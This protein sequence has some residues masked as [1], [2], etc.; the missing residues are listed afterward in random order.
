MVIVRIRVHRRAAMVGCVTW[1]ANAAVWGSGVLSMFLLWDSTCAAGPKP[2]CDIAGQC[3][4]W[5]VCPCGSLGMSRRRVRPAPAVALPGIS[6]RGFA[7]PPHGTNMCAVGCCWATNPSLTWYD[8]VPWQRCR[9]R[10]CC[11]QLVSDKFSSHDNMHAEVVWICS[12]LCCAPCIM[13]D[14][15]AAQALA[16]ALP[17]SF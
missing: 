14:C 16:V 3:R 12:H 7:N 15:W 6:R 17:G 2:K 8:L 4:R 10:T 9:Y 5:H 13:R 1:C 11:M